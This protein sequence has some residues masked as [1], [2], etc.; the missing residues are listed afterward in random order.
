MAR[1]YRDQLR[2]LL[3]RCWA[4]LLC[5]VSILG[6]TFYVVAESKASLAPVEKLI[7]SGHFDEALR[8]L[9]N[10][11]EQGTAEAAYLRGMVYYLKGDMTNAAAAFAIAVKADPQNRSAIEMQGVSLFRSGRPG[12]AAVLLEQAHEPVHSANVDPKYVLGLCYLDLGRYDDA[13]KLFARQYGFNPDSAQ[14][15]LVEA[16][17][18][19][20]RDYLPA[21]E[22]AAQRALGLNPALPKAHLLLG[23]VALAQNQLDRAL[24]EFTKERDADP[25]DGAAYE[26]MGDA[27][28]RNNDF[29]HA[30]EALDRAILL[31]PKVSIPYILLGKTLLKQQNPFMAKM[32]LEHALKMDPNNYVAHYLLGQAYRALDQPEDATREF[33]IVTKIQSASA[34]QL[35]TMGE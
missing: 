5:A 11:K 6:L 13:R 33:Q 23:E 24:A 2:R 28:I 35:N 21:A 14:A 12:E 1:I 34:A 19:L 20:R 7:A 10:S 22:T 25:V 32:Y 30:Q 17:M 8:Q 31:E 26:R 27:Y 29:E 16:R 9:D 3:R 4:S 18:L 15:Y